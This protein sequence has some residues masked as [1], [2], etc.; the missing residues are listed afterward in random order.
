[1]DSVRLCGAWTFGI[2]G[3]CGNGVLSGDAERE[4][5]ERSNDDLKRSPSGGAV[6]LHAVSEGSAVT[7]SGLGRPSHTALILNGCWPPT[8]K[9]PT[10]N[11][12]PWWANIL[13]H[14]VHTSAECPN[15]DSK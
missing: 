4:R 3:P 9:V 6:L 1:M 5:S 7:A 14:G 15:L 13:A 11:G 10:L 8:C 12:T 2:G